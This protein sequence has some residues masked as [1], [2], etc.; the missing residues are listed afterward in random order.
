MDR[1]LWRAPLVVVLVGLMMTAGMWQWVSTSSSAQ[2]SARLESE[3]DLAAGWVGAVLSALRRELDE[4]E[5]A[6]RDEPLLAQADFAARLQPLLDS[7][8]VPGLGAVFFVKPVAAGE[9]AA[10]A[11]VERAAGLPDFASRLAPPT[12]A[13]AEQ[14]LALRQVAA[15]ERGSGASTSLGL[16]PVVW[17]LNVP[18][19][20]DAFRRAERDEEQLVSVAVPATMFGLEPAA[21]APGGRPPAP[22]AAPGSEL[23]LLARWSVPAGGWVVGVLDPAAMVARLPGPIGE[24]AVLYANVTPAALDERAGLSWRE[25]PVPDSAPVP[26]TVAFALA[27]SRPASTGPTSSAGTVAFACL[28]LTVL[29]AM[30]VTVFSWSQR[31]VAASRS[32]SWTDPLTGLANRPAAEVELA[33]LVSEGQRPAILFADIDRF[34]L[35]NDAYGHRAGDEVLRA[36]GQALERASPFGTLPARWGGDEFVVVCPAGRDQARQTASRLLEL[37]GGPVALEGGE[38]AVGMS[39]GLAD[40]TGSATADDA[41]AAAD[42]A[43][44]EAKRQGGG[45]VRVAG[46]ERAAAADELR[47]ALVAGEV[48]VDLEPVRACSP[49][50]PV[51]EVVQLVACPRWP[52]GRHGPVEGAALGELASRSDLGLDLLDEVLSRLALTLSG[53]AAPDVPVVVPVPDA[54]ALD[55]ELGR[56]LARWRARLGGD[57]HRVAIGVSE[58]VLAGAEATLDEL[59]AA[60]LALH[61]EGF[62][63]RVATLAVLAARVPAGVALAP[64]V[65]AHLAESDPGGA[66]RAGR[67]GPVGPAPDALLVRSVAAWARLAGVPLTAAGVTCHG[68]AVVLASLGVT[69][70]RGPLSPMVAP[71]AVASLWS[72]PAARVGDPPGASGR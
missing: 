40:I 52:G 57:R 61:I 34:K 16:D 27:A 67:P 53:P 4:A 66:G 3:V 25:L 9:L 29:S 47:C 46:D 14:W 50:E 65:I 31:H 58:R 20:R 70:V 26:G 22:G 10:L 59:A 28:L 18:E 12:E 2:E 45:R 5:R 69:G 30:T 51:G 13:G 39:V 37:V 35:V 24:R 1:R 7:G 17:D 43:M 8:A 38:V 11:G 21:P 63:G 48:L 44:Y 19:V 42:A 60:G 68:Q 55:P 15:A 33:R 62:D 49:A 54:V 41:L 36:V 23:W 72:P 64:S 56:R 71:L 32:R 6:T